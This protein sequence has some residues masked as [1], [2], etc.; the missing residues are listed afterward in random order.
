[1]CWTGETIRKQNVVFE[2]SSDTEC[3]LGLWIWVWLLGRYIKFRVDRS[4]GI[5]YCLSLYGAC[6][7]SSA[8]EFTNYG[9]PTG[10]LTTKGSLIIF[11][12]L[13]TVG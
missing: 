1:M 2:M 5:W 6:D 9:W 3:N 4:D 8:V 11:L 13:L 10:A 7:W 12:I